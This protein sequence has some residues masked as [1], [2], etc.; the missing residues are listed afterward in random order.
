AITV[1]PETFCACPSDFPAPATQTNPFLIASPPRLRRER[2]PP[3]F[4][5]SDSCQEIPGPSADL[6][7]DH[8]WPGRWA[9]VSSPTQRILSPLFLA[10][11]VL[12][13][14]DARGQHQDDLFVLAGI[15]DI[16][17]QAV[18]VRN[19]AQNGWPELLTSLARYCP[20]R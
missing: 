15:G 10:L 20:T 5:A 4:P 6:H 14:D 1:T 3:G 19:L 8:S 2:C 9:V 13:H 12:R 17:E 16:V 7:V 11:G 18:D